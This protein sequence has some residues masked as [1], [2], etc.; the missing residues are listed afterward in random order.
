MHVKLIILFICLCLVACQNSKTQP[1]NLPANPMTLLN[2]SLF[3]K[4]ET[5]NTELIFQLDTKQQSEFLQFYQAQKNKE[6][7]SSDER[8]IF[9]FLD[10][11]LSGFTFHGDTLDASTAFAEK[12]GNCISLA[13]FTTALA[14]LI[15]TPVDYQVV[16]NE[17]I[18]FKKGSLILSS[19]HLRTRLY[20]PDDKAPKDMIFFTPK[21]IVIDYFPTRG[22]V[23]AQRAQRPQLIAKYYA[24]LAAEALVKNN[25]NLTFSYLYTAMLHDP[26]NSE[27]IN[28]QAVL[29]RRA[30]DTATAIKLYQYAVEN[31]LANINLY[32]NYLIVAQKNNS[33][34]LIDFLNK[35]LTEVDDPN[36]YAWIELGEQA[37]KNNNTQH[38]KFYFHKAIAAAHYIPEPYV[39]L[40]KISYQNGQLNKANNYLTTAIE[41]TYDKTKLSIYRAKYQALKTV[42]GEI[43]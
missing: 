36:P 39:E 3:S 12:R 11:K 40:A 28:L 30:G 2:A 5:Y 14:D 26:Y 17:P 29:H 10:A 37:L 32:Q 27:L 20:N 25:F 23:T 41:R 9:N 7:P 21:S 16:I 34:P 8:I 15:K 33:Q 35:K 6:F 38:A 13:V 22:Q 1:N 42:A 31:N 24:N 4:V 18:Y 19:S 43:N